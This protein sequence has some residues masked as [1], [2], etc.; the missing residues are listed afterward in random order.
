MRRRKPW[1]GRRHPFAILSLLGLV[2]GCGGGGASKADGGQ[3]GTAVGN[4]SLSATIDGVAWVSAANETIVTSTA[5]S[6]G[7]FSI[8]GT[9]GTPTNYTTL[10]LGLGYIGSAPATYPLGVNA[11]TTPGGTATVLGIVSSAFSDWSTDLS[12]S[13]GTITFATFAGGRMTGSFLFTAPPVAGTGTTGTRVVT[14][15]A[16]DLPVPST[17]TPPSGFDTGS[18]VSATLNGQPWNAATVEG[19][20][21]TSTGVLSIVGTTS[22]I[23]ISLTTAVPVAVGGTYDQTA[24][25]LLTTG[26]GSSCCWGGTGLVS[27]V[28]VTS[29]DARRA[30]GTFTAT[31]PAVASS[32]ATTALT[33]TGGTF[34]VRIDPA[35]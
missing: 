2:A 26:S 30:A 12:G 35:S 11:A 13:A 1:N 14:S 34:D 9:Q 20:G 6:P 18:I 25:T 29:L 3:T 15:G 33:I 10:S 31:L 28:T 19:L 22:G 23:S 17:F 21:D 24:V 5:T 32:G 4:G 27:S 8:S 7:E 16:F